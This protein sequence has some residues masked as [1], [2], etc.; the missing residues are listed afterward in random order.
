MQN[1]QQLFRERNLAKTTAAKAAISHG[2][3]RAIGSRPGQS[4]SSH[5]AKE[6]GGETASSGTSARTCTCG[7]RSVGIGAAAS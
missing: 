3:A 5:A 6:E 2:L 4:R 7:G 1:S